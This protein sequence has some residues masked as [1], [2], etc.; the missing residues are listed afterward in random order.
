MSMDVLAV[1]AHPDDADLGVGGTL[2]KLAAQGL[3]TGILD[4]CRGERRARS[5]IGGSAHDVSIEHARVVDRL[6][7]A[8]VR[9]R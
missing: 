5:E 1:G 4:L 2:L 8:D 9:D 7:D 6:S 3:R